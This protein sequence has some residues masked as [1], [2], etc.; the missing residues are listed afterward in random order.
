M[1]IPP[2]TH[3]VH[4]ESHLVL[5]VLKGVMDSIHVAFEVILT[6]SSIDVYQS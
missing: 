4:D 6:V 2:T 3:I 1:Y 5:I